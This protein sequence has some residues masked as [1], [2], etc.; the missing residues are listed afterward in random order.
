MKATLPFKSISVSLEAV[1]LVGIP[2]IFFEWSEQIKI[3]LTIDSKL[4]FYNTVTSALFSC[5]WIPYTH[6][7]WISLALS[8]TQENGHLFL[9]CT[10]FN[11]QSPH[12]SSRCDWYSPS[13]PHPALPCSAI[14]R[15]TQSYLTPDS[16]YMDW[17]L[18][19]PPLIRVHRHRNWTSP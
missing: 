6:I 14:M 1:G 3:T 4:M 19:W 5:P 13:A 17:G 15:R 7:L 18:R 11:K 8:N 9:I 2:W 10:H 12:T 16:L